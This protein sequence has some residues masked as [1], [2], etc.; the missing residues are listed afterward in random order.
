MPTSKRSRSPELRRGQLLDAA[1]SVAIGKG[2]GSLTVAAVASSA[3][4]AKGTTYLYFSS[5]DELIDALRNH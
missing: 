3:G 1:E 4:V 5:K 2:L